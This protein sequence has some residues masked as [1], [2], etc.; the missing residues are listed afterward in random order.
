MLFVV[1]IGES[2]MENQDMQSRYVMIASWRTGPRDLRSAG[3]VL[4]LVLLLGAAR[5]DAW[6]GS[7]V[8]AAG[9][10]YQ[11]ARAARTQGDYPQALRHV[12]AGLEVQPKDLE[13]LLL[14]A[15]LLH[16]MRRCE[17]AIDA[18]DQYLAAGPPRG[19]ARQVRQ[20]LQDLAIC[21]S[22]R[23][24]ISVQGGPTRIYLSSK[25][26]G[27]L[28]QATPDRPC[29]T[30]LI[31][32]RHRIIAERPGFHPFSER[33]RVE[34]GKTLTR[35]LTLKQR[36]SR[37]QVTVTPSARIE[38]DG[39]AVVDS[40]PTYEMSA[41]APGD[42][43]LRLS[44]PG[45][46]AARDETVT[47][48]RGE[49]VTLEVTLRE[50]LAV[51]IV[52]QSGASA[53][54]TGPGAA[55]EGVQI[56]LDLD[57]ESVELAG[58]ELAGE[59][60]LPPGAGAMS[61]GV[62]ATGYHSRTVEIPAERPEDCALTIA[63][64]PI[65]GPAV[66]TAPVSRPGITDHDG[67]EWTWWKSSALAAAGALV[68]ASGVYAVQ[69]TVSSREDIDRAEAFCTRGDGPG[70]TCS[71]EGARLL[72]TARREADRAN[73]SLAVTAASTVGLV[74]A[75]SWFEGRDDAHDGLSTRRKIAL[76]VTGGVAVASLATASFHGLRSRSRR[77][78]A[79][80]DCTDE[81]ACGPRGY[82]LT[83]MAASDARTAN[84]FL[85]ATGVAAVG[86]ALL[87]W[88]GRG[89]GRSDS[90]PDVRVSLD[91]GSAGLE[92]AGA[93]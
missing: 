13:L 22:T 53:G 4:I 8:A 35:A 59:L 16:D 6:A 3:T 26:F 18:Y 89:T 91:S 60:T 66:A 21:R 40:G 43:A 56:E 52:E 1:S 17:P 49:P 88:T 28:C 5:A 37:L 93:F 67:D 2:I 44:A 48:A 34:K 27:V 83:T 82:A 38:L 64:T 57:G 42:H 78:D 55:L 72:T 63:L 90:R 23:L 10:S 7:A 92:V 69:Q 9:E 62:R 70:W 32:G 51:T 24:V 41:L 50:Q 11:E 74:G 12:R 80:L 39:A 29:D 77:A 30:G 14:Y 86:T 15:E 45:C 25:S 87:W 33:V 79:A 36:P 54:R 31:P 84:S 65:P 75:W 46:F 73:L 81:L 71:E 58:G 61:L 19:N 85:V 76:G 47:A 20:M 68:V